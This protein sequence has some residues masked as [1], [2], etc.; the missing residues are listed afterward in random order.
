MD[1][2]EAQKQTQEVRESWKELDQELDAK[3]RFQNENEIISLARNQRAA[4]NAGVALLQKFLDFKIEEAVA[5]GRFNCYV[6]FQ[7]HY[8]SEY[9]ECN[10]YIA[11]RELVAKLKGQKFMVEYCSS[12]R[13]IEIAVEWRECA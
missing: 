3:Q 1:A 2:T 6:V 7:H 10:P 13:G 5:Q 4:V 9:L 8:L 12:L 11:A